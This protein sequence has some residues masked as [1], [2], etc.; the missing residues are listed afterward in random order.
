MGNTLA[1]CAVVGGASPRCT[2]PTGGAAGK[3]AKSLRANLPLLQTE[4]LTLRAPTV[5]DFPVWAEIFAGDEA[6]HIGGPMNMEAAWSAFTGY[7]ACWLLHGFGIFAVETRDAKELVGFVH[8]G[9][10]R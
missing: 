3:A 4:R 5:E 7:V 9:L 10:G 1:F 8:V 2:Q 6:G